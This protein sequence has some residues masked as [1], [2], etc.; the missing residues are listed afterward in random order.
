MDIGY[1]KTFVVSLLQK[2]HSDDSEKNLRLSKKVKI[3]L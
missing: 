3:T 2:W 1:H